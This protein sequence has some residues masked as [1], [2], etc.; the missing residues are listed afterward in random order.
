MSIHSG[1]R[2]GSNRVASTHRVLPDS[3]GTNGLSNLR[4]SGAA[5]VVIMYG[6]NRATR[7]T[8][9]SLRGTNFRRIGLLGGNLVS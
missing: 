5:P 9:G 2:F 1:S 4:G 7:T 8:T 6:A 3:V